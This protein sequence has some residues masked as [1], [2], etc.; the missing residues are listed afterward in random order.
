M[1]R[2]ARLERTEGRLQVAIIG[3]ELGAAE[4]RWTTLDDFHCLVHSPLERGSEQEW[5]LGWARHQCKILE[6]PC[7]K[8]LAELPPGK[9]EDLWHYL[10]RTYY[11]YLTLRIAHVEGGRG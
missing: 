1:S 2:L 10:E 9:G 11:A 7:W 6:G 4:A 3:G 5:P 8:I